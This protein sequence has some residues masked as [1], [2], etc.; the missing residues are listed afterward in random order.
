MKRGRRGSVLVEVAMA[1]V[2][3]STLLVGA[4]FVGR[5]SLAARRAHALARHAAA[6]AAVGV[7]P[8]VLATELGDYARHLNVMDVSWSTGRYAGSSSAAF[9]RL[10]EAVVGVS[11]SVPA[12]LGGPAASLTERAVVEEDRP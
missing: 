6:L 11:L 7:P 12:L 8:D 5:V 10:T 2:V 4:L 1:C 9:Y 3:A